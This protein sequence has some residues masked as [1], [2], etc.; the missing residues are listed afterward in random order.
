MMRAFRDQRDAIPV[1]HASEVKILDLLMREPD[2]ENSELAPRVKLSYGRVKNVMT[3]LLN[4]FGVSNRHQLVYEAKRRGYFPGM[5]LE[6]LY[7][8]T[9]VQRTRQA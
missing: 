1:M 4:K 5:P 7:Q 9:G 8:Y 6:K 3:G 2:M